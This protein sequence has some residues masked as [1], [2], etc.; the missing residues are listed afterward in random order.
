MTAHIV[1]H[2]IQHF[3]GC[4]KRMPILVPLRYLLLCLLLLC[5]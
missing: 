3:L 2:F 1:Q 5:S 4:D